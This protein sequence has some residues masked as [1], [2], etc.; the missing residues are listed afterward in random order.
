MGKNLFSF[1]AFRKLFLFMRIPSRNGK[2]AKKRPSLAKTVS[3]RFSG[4]SNCPS[5]LNALFLLGPF[6]EECDL[7][8]SSVG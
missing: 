6:G 7:N 3:A 4:H 2:H 5:S 1:L 8:H